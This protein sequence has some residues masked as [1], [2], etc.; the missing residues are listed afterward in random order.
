MMSGAKADYGSCAHLLKIILGLL[1]RSLASSSEEEEA[2]E[3]S[4]ILGTRGHPNGATRS[5]VTAYRLVVIGEKRHRVGINET[6]NVW[7]E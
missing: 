7:K 4:D 2:R 6:G 5:N 3:E 1:S